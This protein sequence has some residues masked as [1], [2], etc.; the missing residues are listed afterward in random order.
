ML[1]TSGTLLQLCKLFL[2]AI[3]AGNDNEKVTT[4]ESVTSSISCAKQYFDDIG[5]DD[6]RLKFF[7]NSAARCGGVQQVME[8][9]FEQGYSRVWEN[10]FGEIDISSIIR[11]L[12]ALVRK[13]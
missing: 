8:W 3:L 10:T 4:R 7:W 1:D 2:T 9:A 12:H 5:A 13:M 11:L 6:E